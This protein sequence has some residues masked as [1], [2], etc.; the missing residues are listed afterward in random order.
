[1]NVLN[2][3]QAPCMSQIRKRHFDGK[4]RIEKCDSDGNVTNWSVGDQCHVINVLETQTYGSLQMWGV[5]RYEARAGGQIGV[6]VGYIDFPT[7]KECV[8]YLKE[9]V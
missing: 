9:C 1:M 7:V 3:T 2:L 8:K 5:S 4:H 6:L